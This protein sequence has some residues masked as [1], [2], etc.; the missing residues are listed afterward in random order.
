LL[1]LKGAR[2]GASRWRRAERVCI[3][4]WRR[5]RAL[6]AEGVRISGRASAMLDL[7]DGLAGDALR[8][9][10]ASRVRLLVDEELLRAALRPELVSVCSA[11]G[12]DALDVALKG[13]EDYALLVTSRPSRRLPNARRIG[14][15]VAGSGA[16][17]RRAA[18]GRLSRLAG[19]FDH[20]A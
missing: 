5:P 1:L 15:V 4:R 2:P 6:I 16:F 11:L 18:G 12:I 17:L 3:D 9:A 7:S 20:F 10:E 14:S 19:G 13:G 8:L